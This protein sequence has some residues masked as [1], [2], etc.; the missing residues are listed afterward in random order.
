MTTLTLKITED[1]F[2]TEAYRN[3]KPATK[4]EIKKM[5]ITFLKYILV[6]E[7]ARVNMYA[8]L[9]ALHDEAEANGLT[10]DIIVQLLRKELS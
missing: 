7:K 5:L 9:D 10:D 1:E 2:L 8:T 6:R 3:S 4:R